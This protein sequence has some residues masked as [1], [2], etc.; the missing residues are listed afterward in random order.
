MGLGKTTILRSYLERVDQSQLK[1]IHL[2]HPN[3]SFRELLHT[4]CKECGGEGTTETIAE[5]IT[6][7]HHVLI[8][9]YQQ[10]RQ[11]GAAGR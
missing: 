5:T 4:L 7:L 6:R 2:L 8:Q 10:G 9:E 1:P 3:L 11:C